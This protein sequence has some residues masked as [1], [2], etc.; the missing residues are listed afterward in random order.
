MSARQSIFGP[1]G[2][3]GSGTPS[4]FSPGDVRAIRDR[5]MKGSGDFLHE[6]VDP[7]TVSVDP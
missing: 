5:A 4:R 7:A 2:M 1:A 6:G 3:G